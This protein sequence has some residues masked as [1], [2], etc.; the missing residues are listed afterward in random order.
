MQ[1]LENCL[2]NRTAWF[3]GDTPNF[4]VLPARLADAFIID[5]KRHRNDCMG[6]DQRRLAHGCSFSSKAAALVSKWNGRVRLGEQR[7]VT[8]L[9]GIQRANARGFPRVNNCQSREPV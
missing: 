5:S 1:N 6:W 2:G 3:F 7:L 8:L 9:P 4:R